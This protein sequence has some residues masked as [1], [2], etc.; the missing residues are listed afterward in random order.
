MF[1]Y[2]TLVY[3]GSFKMIMSNLVV[4][5]MLYVSVDALFKDP[6]YNITIATKYCLVE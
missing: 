3:F 4:C 2:Y 1:K 5:L 6:K